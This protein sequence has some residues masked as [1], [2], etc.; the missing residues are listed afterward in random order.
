MSHIGE[1]VYHNIVS[2]EEKDEE[3]HVRLIV[4]RNHNH[5]IKVFTSSH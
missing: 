2:L 1:K 5:V 3:A 4:I